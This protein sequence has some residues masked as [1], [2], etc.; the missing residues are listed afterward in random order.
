MKV[1]KTKQEWKEQLSAEE[2]YVCREHGTESAFSGKFYDNK[3]NGLYRCICC[4][5]PLFESSTKFDS[6]TGWPSYFEAIEDA[7]V[8]NVDTS[9]GMRRVEVKCSSC[10]AHLGHIFPDGPEP[11]GMRYCINSVCLSFEKGEM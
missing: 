9:Y 2:F 10:D 4:N 1:I 11:T 3:E 7:I 6:G 8:E 5:K